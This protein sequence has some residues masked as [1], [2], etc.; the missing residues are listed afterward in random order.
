MK[1]VLS[2]SFFLFVFLSSCI[3]DENKGA[4]LKVGDYLPD[5]EVVMNDGTVV[6]DESLKGKTS[7]IVFFNTLCGDCQ[8]ELPVLQ[9]LYDEYARKDIRF[10]LISREESSE[11]I[12]TYW[13]GNSLNMPYSAQKNRDVYSKFAKMSIP[14]IYINDK[15]GIIRYIYT[16][17]PVPSYD[18]I[19]A[20]LDGLIR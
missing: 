17:N 14:R 15:D 12:E 19:K 4:D 13:S 16:D 2:I 7:V 10:I 11:S 18:V 9:D 8:K 20:S 5:F 3:K 1:R 6:S